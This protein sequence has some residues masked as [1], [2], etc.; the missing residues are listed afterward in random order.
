M[1]IRVATFNDIDNNLLNLYIEGFNIH[2]ENRKDIFKKKTNEELK[3][4]L[5]DNLNNK[6]RKF[7]VIELNNNIIGYAIFEYK[8]KSTNSLW[9]DQIIIDKSYRNKGYG[10]K[11]MDELSKFTLKNNC[12]RIELNCWS[13]NKN[14]LEFYEKLGFIKQSVILERNI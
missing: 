1:N 3:N 7:L 13:F 12:K 10:K 9:I 11:I 4:E 8:Y 5:I 2:Y 6:E 14:A